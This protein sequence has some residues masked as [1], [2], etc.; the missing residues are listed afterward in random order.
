M[1]ARATD[2]AVLI[3][4]GGPV[5]LTAAL[6]LAEAGVP[7]RLF[8]AAP[9]VVE[10]LR[11][12]TF[13][14]PTLDMLDRFGIS[15]EL[16]AR[17]LICPSWQ[18][19]MHPSGE[20]AEFDLSCLAGETNHPYRLQCEQWKLSRAL[21]ERLR[22]H[23]LVDLRYATR[24]VA[25]AQSDDGVTLTV[26]TA[27]GNETHNARFLIAADGAR[28]IVRETLGI[29]FEGDTYPETTMLCATEFPFHEHLPG[30]SHVNYCWK[31]GGT[32]SLLRLPGLWRASF[33]PKAEQSLDE[34]LE[35]ASLREHLREAV[36][37]AE[38]WPIVAKRPYRI[39]QRIA[40]RYRVGRIFL[41]G[42]AAHLNSPSGGMG[43]NG[44]IHDAFNLTDKLAR[45]LRG[46]SEALLDRY[47]SERRPVAME[48]IIAQA[49]ANRAR[50]QEKNDDKRRS[51][52]ANL[53]AV[54]ADP[55]RRKEYLLKT[56]MITG[57]RQAGRQA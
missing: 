40:D 33:Y 18:V 27:A 37:G 52:L 5:G 2:A 56:S 15:A 46:E 10:E 21:L 44:G 24:A 4:G 14:P 22:V 6:C 54:A 48:Q 7:V 3:A 47:E 16:I 51:I 23:P 17:G 1:S 13:H 31:A 53:Q 19:R 45:V 34:A 28:S 55:V 32:F 9:D 12:S 50:M 43:M 36:P 8:E 11:A 29:G 57:L 41:A 25:V 38:E 26:E 39:H 49:D 20:R 35:D 30:L 42:D